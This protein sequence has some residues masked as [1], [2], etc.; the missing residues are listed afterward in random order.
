MLLK[1]LTRALTSPRACV[2]ILSK[3]KRA[4]GGKLSDAEAAKAIR[5]GNLTDLRRLLALD[6]AREGR[7]GSLNLASDY[8]VSS[9]CDTPHCPV[10]Q[11]GSFHA[12]FW[13]VMQ[14]ESLWSKGGLTIVGTGIRAG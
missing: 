8:T 3:L 14:P 10:S 7:K 1:I 13:G 11:H 2:D 4:K 12:S 6:V 9:S 5:T